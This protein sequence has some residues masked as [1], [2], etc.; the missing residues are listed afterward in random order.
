[1]VRL[2]SAPLFIFENWSLE[3]RSE[4]STVEDGTAYHVCHVWRRYYLPTR[5][6]QV[7]DNQRSMTEPASG[8][9]LAQRVAGSPFCS[10]LTR[11]LFR[12]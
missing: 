11:K 12:R 8:E 1:M 9:G 3:N 2:I 6:A 4:I 5:T 10:R 7:E